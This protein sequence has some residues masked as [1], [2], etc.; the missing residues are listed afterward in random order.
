MNLNLEGFFSEYV[1]KIADMHSREEVLNLLDYEFNFDKDEAIQ[2]CDLFS[3]LMA[4]KGYLP[5]RNKKGEEAV[6]RQL[7]LMID[8]FFFG[9]FLAKHKLWSFSKA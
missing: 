6:N 9:M 3:S 4:R 5:K 7:E 1:K 2:L 8:S